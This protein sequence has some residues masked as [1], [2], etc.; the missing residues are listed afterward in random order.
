MARSRR[1]LSPLDRADLERL[2]LRYVERFATTRARL[3]AY[4]ER[5]IRERGWAGEAAPETAAL[6]ERMAELGYVDDRAFAEARAGAMARRGLG[7]R[8]VSEALRHAG[9]DGEDAAALAPDVEAR[10]GA[11]ALAFAR[12]KRIGPYARDPADRPLREKQLA[13]M[14]RAGHPIGLA[15]AIVHMAPGEDVDFL[16]VSERD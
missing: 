2:A 12:R 7:A 3:A 9:V 5:K 14:L 8:R 16:I 1:P 10:A 13:A 6:A 4:L 11:S 15:R